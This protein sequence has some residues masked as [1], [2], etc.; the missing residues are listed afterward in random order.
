SNDVENKINAITNSA[1]DVATKVL[2]FQTLKA[3]T[4]A[5]IRNYE[6]AIKNSNNQLEIAQWQYQIQQLQYQQSIIDNEVRALQVQ[7]NVSMTKWIV[8]GVAVV[9]VLG[10]VIFATKYNKK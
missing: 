6:L 3:N 5:S 10:I 4:E 2:E 7:G 1:S 8:G 9:A